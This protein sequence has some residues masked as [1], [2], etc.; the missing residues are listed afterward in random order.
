MGKWLPGSVGV[1]YGKIENSKE[2]A[3]NYNSS[4]IRLH[5]S[6]ITLFRFL[7]LIETHF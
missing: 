4:L 2:K 3:I 6:L 1:F 5:K 7:A